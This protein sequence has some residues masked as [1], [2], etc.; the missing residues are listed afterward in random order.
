VIC[1]VLR[2]EI[3]WQ[4]PKESDNLPQ[5][6]ALMKTVQRLPPIRQR[7]TISELHSAKKLFV[8]QGPVFVDLDLG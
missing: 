3:Q 1:G 6:A 2:L 8:G 5:T 7:R 4:L